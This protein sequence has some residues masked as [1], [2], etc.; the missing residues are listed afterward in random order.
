MNIAIQC[1][2]VGTSIA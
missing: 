2:D 1:Q